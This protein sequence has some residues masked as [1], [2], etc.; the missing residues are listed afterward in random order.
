MLKAD[1]RNHLMVEDE[2]SKLNK[3]GQI[4]E[5]DTYLMKELV[6]EIRVYPGNAVQ[7]IWNFADTITA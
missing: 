5:I 6:K 3:H 2:V 1:K 4:T 7:I